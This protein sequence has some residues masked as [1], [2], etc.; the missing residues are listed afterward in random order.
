[1]VLAFLPVESRLGVDLS[2][3]TAF[4]IVLTIVIVI[5]VIVGIVEHLVVLMVLSRVMLVRSFV[6]MVSGMVWTL[7]ETLF[8]GKTRDRGHR[9]AGKEI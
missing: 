5:V 6:V 3:R 4:V 8:G 7:R 2:S 9:S 1:M